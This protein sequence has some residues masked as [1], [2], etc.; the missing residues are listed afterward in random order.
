M[1]KIREFAKKSKYLLAA[2][3]GGRAF[4]WAAKESLYSLDLAG[5]RDYEFVDRRRNTRD[6]CIVLAG[7]KE[8]IWDDIFTRLRT[9]IPEDMDVCICTS[10]KTV[11]RLKEMCRDNQWS[12]L[13]TEK[14]QVCD[15][16]NMAI[17]L[18]PSAEWI[19]KLDED[20]FVT[21]YF[22]TNLRKRIQNPPP[23]YRIGFVAPLIPINGYCY[24]R[25]LEKLNLIGAWEK[26]F[27]PAYYTD[28]SHHSVDIWKNPEAAEFMWGKEEARLQDIDVLAE[29]FQ[30]MPDAYSLCNI[31]Y[32]IGAIA[33]PRE[34]WQNICKEGGFPMN[35]PSGL[36]RDEEALCVHCLLA[37]LAMVVDE[38]TIVGHL[39]FGQQNQEMYEFYRMHKERFACKG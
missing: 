31:R 30:N 5:R 38:N 28:C 39:S 14:N 26:H 17:V 8:E 4:R 12:Y 15:I 22:F 11:D 33:F 19:F 1:S 29:E 21:K 36:G 35:T 18:H 3:R 13:A 37:G 27:N 2:V 10:G 9:Y 16:Q 24:V 25:V 6:L 23:R 7:Y 34:V 32:S 20:I